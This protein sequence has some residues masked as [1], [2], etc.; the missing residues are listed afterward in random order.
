MALE[1]SGTRLPAGAV[2]RY[3]VAA[4]VVA[5]AAALTSQSVLLS[6]R[7]NSF[8]F[9]PVLI[10]LAWFGGTGPG[11]FATA[12]SAAA[13]IWT[14]ESLRP[15]PQLWMIIATFVLIGVTAALLSGWRSKAERA[16]RA[17]LNEL[18]ASR[19]LFSLLANA[20]PVLVWMS[21]PDGTR[22]NFNARWLDFT[23]RSLDRELAGGWLEAVHRD[24]RSRLL[25]R[26]AQAV[27][28]GLP[29]EIE[30]RLQRT[31]GEYRVV[32]DR[33][34]PRFLA[35]GALLGYVG[36]C[37]DISAQREALRSAEEARSA[38]EEASRA[39]DTFLATVSHE[40]RSPLTPI[41]AY[42]HM[43][44]RKNLSGSQFDDAVAAIDRNARLQ[45]QLVEDLMD[46]ARIA[47]GKLRVEM[48]PV[49]LVDVVNDAVETV[50]PAADAKRVRLELDVD[51]AVPQVLGDARRLQ[52]V[53][54]NLLAN[55]VKFTLAGGTV[56][57]GLSADDTHV[58]VIVRD[59]GIGIASGQL[60]HVFETFWQAH[61][62]SQRTETGLGIG[63]SLVRDL[64]E[65]HGGTVKAESSG[66]GRGST[67]TFSLPIPRVATA[68][69]AAGGES[70]DELTMGA[71]HR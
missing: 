46:A 45:A 36:S 37:T 69:E 49:S 29:F 6:E 56:H 30:Y 41:F 13:L 61:G 39:K 50:R 2:T 67:F 60:P 43:L 27:E 23:G 15:P 63:L 44:R 68:S 48:R 3:A 42:V 55:A 16:L 54:W 21:G 40:L 7:F 66:E 38:A 19:D 18:R 65:L 52:Q 53:V 47:G 33:G 9:W 17:T 57:V 1:A 31:D 14:D 12:L 71:P 22:D 51:M 58:D 59:D 8:L 26:V 70:L 11:L 4:V 34:A 32:L 62:S 5:G 35:D 64:V 28:S 10:A 24:D 25:T 20:A